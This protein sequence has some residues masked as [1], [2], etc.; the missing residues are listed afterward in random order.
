MTLFSFSLNSTD[1]SFRLNSTNSSF[2]LKKLSLGNN[3]PIS[4]NIYATPNLALE[5]LDWT[6][7]YQKLFYNNYYKIKFDFFK[8][9][10]I[11]V[12]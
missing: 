2:R 8:Q 12:Q 10:M 3:T 7:I 1:S 5:K 9:S 11:F 4:I 6:I